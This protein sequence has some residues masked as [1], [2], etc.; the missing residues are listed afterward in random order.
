MTTLTPTPATVTIIVEAENLSRMMA[1]SALQCFAV[2]D[3][4]EMRRA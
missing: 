4:H 1:S 3:S 2:T